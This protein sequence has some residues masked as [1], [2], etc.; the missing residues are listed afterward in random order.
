MQILYS[1]FDTIDFSIQGS[2]PAK[3]LDAIAKA[4]AE[5]EKRQ[6]VVLLYAGPKGIPVHVHESGLPGGY[7]FRISTG[8][9]GEIIGIKNNLAPDQ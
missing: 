5:A 9:L 2:L 3:T 8:P 7:A 6:G 1:G 4:K